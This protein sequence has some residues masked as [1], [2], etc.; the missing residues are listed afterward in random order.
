ML[1]FASISLYLK[2]EDDTVS[3][4]TL[5]WSKLVISIPLL[6]LGAVWT[7]SGSYL[8]GVVALMGGSV[9][10]LSLA[11]SPIAIYATT[12]WG[13]IR[14]I[15]NRRFGDISVIIV[16]IA[17]VSIIYSYQ[18]AW[19]CEP[20]AHSGYGF[21][22]L[23]TAELYETGL[24]GVNARRDLARDWYLDAAYSG[25]ASAQYWVGMHTHDLNERRKWLT[26]AANQGYVPAA[27]QIFILFNREDDQALEWLHFAADKDYPPALY[28]LGSLHSNGYRVTH[29]LERTR[30]LWHRAAEAGHTTAMRS[31]AITYARGVIFDIDLGASREWEQKAIAASTN[32]DIKRLPAGERH[33]AKTWQDQ[34]DRVRSQATTIAASDSVALRQLS[35]DILAQSKDDPVQHEK[36]IRLLELSAEDKPDAQYKVADYYLG[37]KTADESDTEKGL[38]WLA[39]AAENGHRM[40]LRRLIEA[41]KEGKYGLA[42]D[43]YK[44]KHYSERYFTVLED[45]GVAQ[46]NAVRLAPSWDYQDTLNQIK[47]IEELPLSP[48]QLK[49]KADA[50]DPE[51][52]YYLA[53]DIAFYGN[54]F[55]TMMA[56]LGASALAG[57]PQAQYEMSSRIFNRKHTDEEERQAMEW[58]ISAAKGGHR[59]ALVWLGNQYMSGFKRQQIERNYYQAKLLYESAIAGIDGI[60]Y[61][62]RT[63]PTRSWHITVDSVKRR[64]DKIPDYIMRLDL[65]GLEGQHRITA[66]NDWYEQERNKLYVSMNTANDEKFSELATSLSTLQLQHEILLNAG[67]HGPPWESIPE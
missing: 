29:D 24:G 11:L 64:L 49:A 67:S 19:L 15:R 13:L 18:R 42:V 37:L 36:G 26:Q 3:R 5:F 44:A 7:Y 56:L 62:Q 8:L 16:I 41:Y 6:S 48:D 51:A 43:L 10:L 52:Q 27:Y 14:W 47:R 28:R 60:V 59:G 23:C 54:D 66:I 34:L 12:T 22:Q 9:G 20:L 21:A 25:Y 50:G 1:L 17:C 57:Y 39:R 46:N 53:K 38:E 58:L 63:S 55:K 35:K 4:Q 45:N 61:K 31:L 65:E 32:E 30:E 33:F 40:A 2:V